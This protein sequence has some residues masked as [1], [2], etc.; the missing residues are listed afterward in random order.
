MRGR[1]R[2]RVQ[3]A[4]H[5]TLAVPVTF[6]LRVLCHVAH[7]GNCAI[8]WHLS[9]VWAM[10]VC[11]EAINQAHKEQELGLPCGKL[12]PY[13]DEE[14]TARQLVFVDGWIYPLFKAAAILYPGVKGRLTD[15]AECRE[16]CKATRSRASRNSSA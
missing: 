16:A 11:D 4:S 6:T 15:I 12:T 14:L 9:S 1:A 3:Q 7:L 13:T 2:A 5:T 10:R 8:K